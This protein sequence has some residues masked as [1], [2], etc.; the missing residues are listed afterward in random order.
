M[1]HVQRRNA[2]W[3]PLGAAFDFLKALVL[4]ILTLVIRICFSASIQF[5]PPW[6]PVTSAATS[7]NFTKGKSPIAIEN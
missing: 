4:G 2:E 5:P 6:P 7:K 3:S 1:E